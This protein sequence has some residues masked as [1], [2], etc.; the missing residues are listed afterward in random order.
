MGFDGGG[1][2]SDDAKILIA[3]ET[4][5]WRR[6]KVGFWGG[7]GDGGGGGRGGLQIGKLHVC[8]SDHDHGVRE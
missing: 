4:A 2:G 5:I 3:I 6:K 1:G 8:E 7:L